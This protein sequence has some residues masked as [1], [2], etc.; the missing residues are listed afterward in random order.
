[1]EIGRKGGGKHWTEA[2]VSARREAAEQLKRKKNSKL[3]PPD[4]LSKEACKIWGEKL[5]Q[6]EGLQAANELLDVLDTEMLAL[7]CDAVAQ[8][9]DIAAQKTKTVDDIKAMQSW[10]RII[11]NF[12]ERLGFTPGARARLVKKIADKSKDKFGSQ[13]D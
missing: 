9:N 2:E 12:A 10:S 11:G 13:F 5:K 3:I 7:Y 6:V 1:M 4:W 8:Y